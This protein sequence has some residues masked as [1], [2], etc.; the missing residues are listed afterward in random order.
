M[1]TV[2]NPGTIQFFMYLF[3][4]PAL[5]A[6]QHQMVWNAVGQAGQGLNDAVGILARADSTGG[7]N[8]R[9]IPNPQRIQQ[10]PAGIIGLSLELR[11]DTFTA[12]LWTR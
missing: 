11:R 9:C 12:S 10:S 3:L 5:S 8:K 1:H 7:Q 2:S 4:R 6:H